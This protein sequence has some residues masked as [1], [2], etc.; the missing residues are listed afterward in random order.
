VI[1]GRFHVEE[2]MAQLGIIISLALRLDRNKTEANTIHLR[3]I[4]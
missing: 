3:D 4:D 2:L 1:K